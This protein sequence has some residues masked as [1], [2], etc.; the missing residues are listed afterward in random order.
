MRK[1]GRS[2]AH[3]KSMLR[4]MTTD[5]IIYERIETTETRAKEVRRMTEKLITLG[6]RG[7]FTAQKLSRKVLFYK[8]DANKRSAQD[9]LF[10]DLAKRYEDRQGGYTRIIKIGPRQ[11]DAAPM[12][13]IELVGNEEE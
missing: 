7:D 4:N 3:R 6:K 8:L 2:S 11:G 9:K 13:I 12:A 10:N 5:L 1:L